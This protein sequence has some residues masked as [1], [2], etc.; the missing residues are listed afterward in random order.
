MSKSKKSEPREIADRICIACTKNFGICDP[1]PAEADVHIA[2][3][4]LVVSC[5]P[6]CRAKA[7]FPERKQ[8]A[9]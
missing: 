8:V 7:G 5:S 4:G 9:S 2:D 3:R 1:L 6:R